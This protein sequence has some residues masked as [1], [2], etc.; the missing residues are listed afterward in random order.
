MT[1]YIVLNKTRNVGKSEQVTRFICVTPPS[2]ASDRLQRLWES[3]LDGPGHSR[4][5]DDKW[6]LPEG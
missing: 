6:V 2:L 1:D 4:T 3:G 5:A